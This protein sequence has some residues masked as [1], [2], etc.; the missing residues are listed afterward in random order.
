MFGI[1]KEFINEYKWVKKINIIFL[2]R[3]M[4][5]IIVGIIY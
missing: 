3:F 5:G 2:F 1:N 4:G